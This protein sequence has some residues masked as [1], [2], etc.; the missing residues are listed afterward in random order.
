MYKYIWFGLFETVERHRVNSSLYVE[1]NAVYSE[2]NNNTTKRAHARFGHRLVFTLLVR[3]EEGEPRLFVQ[4][5]QSA[6]HCNVIQKPKS[7]RKREIE[8]KHTEINV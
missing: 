7:L 6:G 2:Y 5:T 3:E 4:R 8:Q 1:N